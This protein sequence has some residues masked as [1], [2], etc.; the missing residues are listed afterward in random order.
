MPRPKVI[1]KKIKKN[2]RLRKSLIERIKLI[3]NE[4]SISEISIF[5]NGIENYLNDLEK[6][7]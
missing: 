3:S 4:L 5:E 1:D 2:V 7:R 6:R